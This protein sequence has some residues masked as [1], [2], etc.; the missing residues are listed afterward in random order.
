MGSRDIEDSP[1]ALACA[2]NYLVTWGDL[3]AKLHNTTFHYSGDFKDIFEITSASGQERHLESY[4]IQSGG[5]LFLMSSE[6][7]VFMYEVVL[8]Y[9][10]AP[11]FDFGNIRF[12]V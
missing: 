5:S 2:R 11:P 4:R 9:K 8:P 3:K 7:E 6:T 10:T 12:I 1:R